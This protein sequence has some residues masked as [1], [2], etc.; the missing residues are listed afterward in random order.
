MSPG[1]TV[2][3][4]PLSH[5]SSIVPW[6]HNFH[7]SPIPLVLQWPPVAQFSLVPPSHWSS[8]VP[9]F[10]CSHWSPI[11]LVL[12][13][14]LV[15]QLPLVPNP[16]G[17][18]MS[19]GCTV[20]TGPPSHWPSNVPWLHS[21][22]RSP[23]SLVLQC[24]LVAQFSL[25]PHLIGPP[26]S[27]GCAVLIGPTSHWSSNA[28]WLHSSHWS[29]IPLVLQC[30]LVAQ[31]SLVPYL[32]GPPMSPGC[33]V[34][35]DR[36]SHWSSNDPRLQS[37]HWSPISLVLQCPLVA[38]F[39]LVPHPIGPPMTPG[40]TVLIGPPSHWSSMSPGC[41]VLIGPPSHW[42]SNVPW[43][44]SSYWSHISLVLQ[45]PLV[46]QFSLVPHPIG[47]PMTPGC[48]VLIGPPS[49]WSSNVTYLHC[50]HWPPISLVLQWSLVAQFSL[51]PHPIGPSMTPGCTVLIGPP[52]HW[53]S[54]DPWL[55]C[56]HWSPISL[57]LQWPLVAQFSCV[58]HPIGP[59]MSPGCTVLIGPP[60]HWS[61]ND[62]W[63]KSSHWSPIPLVLQCPLVALFS[64]A[65]PP[66]S[67]VLQWP[68]VAQFSLVP[69][70]IGPPMSPGCT[71]LIGPPS[72]WSSNDP[73][74]H[75]SHWS[76]I[77]LVLQCPLVAL[78]SLVP[79][80]IGPPMS[81]GCTVLIGPLSHWS[82]NVPWLRSSH[83]SHISLVLQC[84]L[85]AQFSLVPHPIGPP[86]SPGC[87][88]LIGPPSHWSSNDPWLHSSHWSPISLVLQWPLVAQF[89][90]VP[91]LNGPP[92]SPGCTVLIGPP[93][94][95][96]SN[97]PWLHSSHWPPSHWS[98]NVPWLHCSHWSPI[99]LVLQC[100][101][102]ALFSLVPHPNGPS[103]T[104]G[105]TVL[106]GPPSHW[107]S[108]DPWLHCSH[109]SPIWLVLQ[110]PLV[111]QFSC[112][113]HPIGPPMSPG[114]TVLIGPPSHWS[115]NDP[116][117]QSSHWSTHLIGPPM[118]PGCTVLI[119][120]PPSHWSSNDPWLHS[121]HWSPIPLVLQCPLVA[122]FSLVP[123]PI[124][125]PM[126]PGCTVLIGPPSHWSSN[127]PW[128]RSSHWSHISLV[129]QCPLVAQFSLVPHPI[130]PPM[131]PGCTVLIGP[132]SH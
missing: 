91:H 8:N 9:W 67:L 23:I 22:H 2:L 79:H 88:V 96:S 18:P 122:L 14:P 31:F 15:A 90:L 74:S 47:P 32:I 41:T 55:H 100:P 28:P 54:I 125:P 106:I 20:L 102:V 132:P 42:H 63:L 24:P 40:C 34:L 131:S 120:P 78:F 95:W 53:S 86:M 98:S 107:S 70:P 118:S 129:L 69:H 111:A 19:P 83:W 13:G 46:A 37:Y 62:P 93:S 113:P 68:L 16:I 105:C 94:R 30:P 12:Q 71:V 52:S 43:L 59:P 87:T 124:G 75:C 99:S 48:T 110:C 123:H 126:S 89:S 45:C 104:P 17:P 82:S 119:S 25:V 39:S 10:H 76:P 115:S 103:M 72:H 4:G 77:P 1:C 33:T 81:P 112:V 97:D 109:W 50:S 57:V 128:L 21:S 80:P 11:P 5:W 84:P 49:R 114:C 117:L 73:W 116:W 3:I 26:M 58:P 85:V 61:S 64:L 35:I 60:S 38:L 56:S 66:L 92:M 27:P 6:L 121:S 51:V 101:L 7:W 130:G 36:P 29:P 108:I 44:R 65:P 127:V